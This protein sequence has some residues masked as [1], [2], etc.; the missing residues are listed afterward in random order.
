MNDNFAP[1][2]MEGDDFVQRMQTRCACDIFDAI[3]VESIREVIGHEFGNPRKAE[4]LIKKYLK[5]VGY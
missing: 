2:G 1:E 5:G 4:R 3:I